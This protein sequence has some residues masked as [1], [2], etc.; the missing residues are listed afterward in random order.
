MQLDIKL[1]KFTFIVYDF[2]LN[3]QSLMNV[4]LYLQR[5]GRIV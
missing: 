1:N 2:F 3:S 5:Q 4:S